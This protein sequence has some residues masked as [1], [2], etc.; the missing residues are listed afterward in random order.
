MARLEFMST[1]DMN[2][3]SPKQNFLLSN[4]S[5]LIYKNIKHKIQSFLDCFGRYHEN[6]TNEDVE[7]MAFIMPWDVYHYMVMFFGLN[8]IGAICMR[9]MKII[10]YDIIHT[11]N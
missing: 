5:N 1:K 4:I 6:L 9:V 11:K 10:F 2:N 3:A 8:N 7:K